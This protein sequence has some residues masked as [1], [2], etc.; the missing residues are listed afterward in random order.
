MRAVVLPDFKI[1]INGKRNFCFVAN[2]N[3]NCKHSTFCFD[4]QKR[5]QKKVNEKKIEPVKQIVLIVDNKNVL[6]FIAFKLKEIG[7]MIY[8]NDE[9][10]IG[11]NKIKDLCPQMVIINMGLDGDITE[12]INS[13]IKKIY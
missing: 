8:S 1:W 12:G 4:F 10:M 5:I 2:S 9:I 11:I 7:V 3:N 13:E 6:D